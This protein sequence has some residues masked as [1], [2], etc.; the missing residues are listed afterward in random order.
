FAED[1]P[2]PRLVERPARPRRFGVVLRQGGEQVE[3]RHPERVDHA[4]RPAGEHHVRVPVADQAG[5]LADRLAR[6]GAGGQ[7]VVVRPLQVERLGQV[8]GRRVHLQL[9]LP[10]AVEQLQPVAEEGGGVDGPPVWLVRPGDGRDQV[11]EVVDALAAER[12]DG[13][14]SGNHNTAAVH[15]AV[16]GLRRTHSSHRRTTAAAHWPRSVRLTF[17]TYGFVTGR[18]WRT[19]ATGQAGSGSSQLSVAGSVP[20]PRAS[21]ARTPAPSAITQPSRPLSNGR[22]ACAGASLRRDSGAN[23]HWR[24]RLKRLILLSAAP[25]SM[26]SAASRR[27]MRAASPRASRP[28]TSLSVTELFGPWASRKIDV[29]QATMFGRYLSIQSGWTSRSPSAPHLPSS[30]MPAV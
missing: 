12:G 28:A 24:T 3:P 29:W 13:P 14:H 25:T 2:V 30:T 22:T 20:C 19:T 18:G 6:R 11:G 23:R 27:R 16:S 17:S 7:A 9:L 4:V 5:G 1:E 21:T 10:R 8:R 26:K 15:G